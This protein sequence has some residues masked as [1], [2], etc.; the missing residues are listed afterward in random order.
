[1]KGKETMSE[2]STAK[3]A[4]P[5]NESS[6]LTTN[7]IK[8][9]LITLP[10][11]KVTK[12]DG[13]PHLIRTFTFQNF[14]E[15]LTFTNDVGEIAEKEGHHPLIHLTWGKVTVEWWTHSI[16]GLYQNDFHMAARTS[17]AYQQ[18]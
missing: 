3:N 8:M 1:M 2:S 10:D 13:I 6:P 14:A 16:N 15:A 5:N 12:V 11:W 18:K 7:E 4:S 9:L 17:E